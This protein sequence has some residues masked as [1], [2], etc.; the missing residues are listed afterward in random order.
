MHT[1]NIA[2]R[3]ASPSDK[4]RHRQENRQ[5]TTARAY[6]FFALTVCVLLSTTTPVLGFATYDHV[7]GGEYEL[8][9]T[10]VHDE[11]W[12]ITYRYADDCIGKEK[13]I[14]DE[15]MEKAITK[16]LRVWLQPL[17]DLQTEKPIVNDFRFNQVSYE[18]TSPDMRVKH[19]CSYGTS[20]ARLNHPPELVMRTGVT[21]VTPHFMYMLIHEMGH[22]FG[23]ADTYVGGSKKSTGGL[24]KT[25]GT[26]P[27][28]IMASLFVESIELGIIPKDDW[29]DLKYISQ[30]DANGIVW[31]YKYYH[32]N[33]PLEDCY[34]PDYTFQ[35][36][37]RGCVP[38]H[39]IIFELKHGN[40]H[41][42]IRTI[43]QDPTLDINVRDSHDYTALDYT[44]IHEYKT[45][46]LNLLYYHKN[47]AN[48]AGRDGHTALHLAAAGGYEFGVEKLLAHEDIDVNPVDAEKRAPLH[49]AAEHGHLGVVQLLL[50]HKAID[51]NIRDSK[52]Q[53]ALQVAEKHGHAAI[54]K[55]LLAH[56]GIHVHQSVDVNADGVVNI[57]DVVSVAS[58]LGGRGSS[59]A[60]LNGDG[61]VNIQ[62]LVL[63]ASAL[64]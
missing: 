34:F 23:L 7:W 53:T 57:L 48:A 31:L 4:C 9:I 16:A 64:D 36:N 27:A 3:L 11:Y 51:V 32:E 47:I 18:S 24:D 26:Q 42:A 52:G 45:V 29:D 49:R 22:A 13:K 61:I 2:A 63:V 30:D 21:E 6:T 1:A 35:E 54:V 28:S 20:Q 25:V 15:D 38:I 56:P 50:T 62:D 37:P 12:H 41:L 14:N 10:K 5:H 33:Q 8:L 19:Y 44:V 60:D 40:R 43:R 58:R 55:H 46:F 59:T 17:R 39:P